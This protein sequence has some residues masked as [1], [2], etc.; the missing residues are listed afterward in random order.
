MARPRPCRRSDAREAGRAAPLTLPLSGFDLPIITPHWFRSS[1]YQ[2]VVAL[3]TARHTY[4][5]FSIISY[6][7]SK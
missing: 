6:V 7:F 4:N 5:R 2:S 3:A 1:A